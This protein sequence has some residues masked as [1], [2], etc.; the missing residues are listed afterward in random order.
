MM[1]SDRNNDVSEIR[2]KH[3]Q[4]TRLGRINKHLKL[5]SGNKSIPQFL[6]PYS[7]PS[8]KDRVPLHLQISG[9]KL[10]VGPL[11]H[12]RLEESTSSF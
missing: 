6:T 2:I 12:N 5:Y 7:W 9:I 1:T 8:C 3:K 11:L 4:I 10:E